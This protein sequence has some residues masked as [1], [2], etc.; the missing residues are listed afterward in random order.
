MGN[1]SF[2]EKICLVCLYFTA[3]C[4]YNDTLNMVSLYLMIP[5]ATL[6]CFLKYNFTTIKSYLTPL[7]CMFGWVAISSLWAVYPEAAS[8]QMHQILG[9][10]MLIY[11][12]YSLAKNKAVV[13]HLYFTFVVCYA[14]AW[15]YAQ[16]NILSVIDLST[17]RLSD[18]KLNANTLAYYTFY[19]TFAT[20]MCHQI[21]CGKW[22]QIYLTLFYL[23]IPLTIYTA[24]LTASRQVFIIQIPLISLCL[25]QKYFKLNTKSFLR[26]LVIVFIAYIGYKY[27]LDTM[28]EG[29]ILQERNEAEVEDDIRM[30]L[31]RDAFDVGV[32]HF[33]TGVGAGNFLYYTASRNFS[34]CT[35]LELFANTGIIGALLFIIPL[36]SFIKRQWRR[37]KITKDVLYISFFIFGLIFFA[38]NFFYVFYPDMFLMAFLCLVMSHSDQYWKETKI[39]QY[40]YE[41]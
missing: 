29:S 39:I 36:L 1:I 2:K 27:V 31:L 34:H 7:L 37:Y 14:A 21:C 9:V 13:P 16:A 32:S 10:V 8:R 4:S 33:F 19:Y 17:D 3:A 26:F 41:N 28:Y 30:V 24:F 20:F 12:Y 40:N 6:V 11:I 38:D 15:H 23:A 5:F 25:L 35:Y 22:K 18:P